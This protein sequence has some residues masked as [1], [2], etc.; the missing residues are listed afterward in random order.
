[1]I[2]ADAYASIFLQRFNGGTR[3][4]SVVTRKKVSL[5]LQIKTDVY[6][7]GRT[8]KGNNQPSMSALK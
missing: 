8:V 7:L 2:S 3:S 4:I 1:M 6:A 5:S